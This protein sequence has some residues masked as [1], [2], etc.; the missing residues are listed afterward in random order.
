M[1]IYDP[2]LADIVDWLGDLSASPDANELDETLDQFYDWA[3]KNRVWI[4]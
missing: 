2:D 3:D 4:A 1:V